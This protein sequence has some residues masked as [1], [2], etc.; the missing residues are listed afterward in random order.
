MNNVQSCLSCYGCGL[1]VIQCPHKLIKLHLNKE[2]FY[3][4]IIKDTDTCTNC[5]ACISVC[6]YA[7]DGL[8]VKNEP[9][10]CYAAWSK[11]V[12]IR[13]KC[14]SGGVGFEVARTSINQGYKVLGVK[15]DTHADRAVHYV[16]E[17]AE[18]AKATIGSKYIQSYT[19][20]GLKSINRKEKYLVTGTPCQIDSFRRYIRKF[21]CEDNF[22]LMDFFCHGVPSMHLWKKYIKEAKGTIGQIIDVSWRNKTY[23]WHDS[24]EMIL[25]G[26]KNDISS[27]WTHGNLFYKMFLGNSCLG[28]ACYKKCKFKGASSSADIRIGDL[29]GKTYEKDEKGVSCVIAFTERG[30]CFL[31]KTNCNLIEHPFE[32]VTEGQLNKHIKEPWTRGFI[33]SLLTTRLPLVLIFRVL[34][35]LNLPYIL[36]CKLEKIKKV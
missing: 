6:S 29:W 32:I 10:S 5:G 15:Y 17:T 23:G 22:L 16:A 11:D 34:Q 21:H 26:E 33:C 13:N 36:K 8:A 4:P 12:D 18:G 35:L 3:A 2:G 1:C 27:R 24:W 20:D 7:N 31:N 28:K 30:Q 25:H 9:K 14:S 19:I